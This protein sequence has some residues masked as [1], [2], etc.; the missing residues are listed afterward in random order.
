MPAY[1][2]RSVYEQNR[3]VQGILLFV[4]EA[5]VLFFTFL[6]HLPIGSVPSFLKDVVNTNIRAKIGGYLILAMIVVFM[7]TVLA[8][9]IFREKSEFRFN[10]L[11]ITG[12]FG[13]AT[14]YCSIGL[15]LVFFFGLFSP[16]LAF[17]FGVS[18]IILWICTSYNVLIEVCGGTE[19]IRTI[20]AVL[21]IIVITIIVIITLYLII[22]S[23]VMS[24]VKEAKDAIDSLSTLGG[25]GD[26][27]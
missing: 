22:K 18:T 9:F 14:A 8:G 4:I 27:F 23:K 20:K 1:G 17:V 10:F 2:M 12:M 21:S 25:L 3:G 15:I 24:A 6:I 16:L 11:N 7:L 5:L 13:T 19:D 26:L